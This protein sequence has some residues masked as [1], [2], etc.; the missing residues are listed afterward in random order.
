MLGGCGQYRERP[1][2]LFLTEWKGKVREERRAQGTGR[3]LWLEK[4]GECHRGR[5]ELSLEFLSCVC[6]RTRV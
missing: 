5:F 1:Y 3:L 2:P 4:L 6:V